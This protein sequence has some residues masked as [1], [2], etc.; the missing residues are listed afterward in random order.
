M[1]TAGANPTGNAPFMHQAPPLRRSKTRLY[2]TDHFK[3]RY[4]LGIFSLKS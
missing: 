1:N 4:I 3:K 2:I